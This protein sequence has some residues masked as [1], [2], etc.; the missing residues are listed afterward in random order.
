MSSVLVQSEPQELDFDER[1]EAVLNLT[2]SWERSAETHIR[3]L[4]G[5]HTDTKPSRPLM[6]AIVGIPGSGKST[7][8]N[9]LRCFFE[10]SGCLVLPHDGYHYTID[11]LKTFENA[12]DAIYRRG[13]PD[14]FDTTALLRDLCRIREGA[15]ET[16]RLPGFEHSVG[17]PIAD[18][19]EFHRNEHRIVIC[20]GL[21]LLHDEDGWEEMANFFDYTVFVDA[22]VDKCMERL[23]IRNCC[24]P[25]YTPD[26][27]FRRV[28]AVDRLNALTVDKS[29]RRAHEIFRA[30]AF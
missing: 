25:G 29:R 21:Y 16:I 26:E 24:I 15:E 19:H 27:I 7:C 17:D 8:S 30:A 11:Q 14:T 10:D 13:A 20:E 28:D 9:A 5:S 1:V 22:D 6:I 12:D 3:Q 18:M 23:K 4:L 2:L